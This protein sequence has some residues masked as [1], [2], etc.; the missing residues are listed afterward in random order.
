MKI[1]GT[2]EQR[3]DQK[4]RRNNVKIKGNEG[5]ME[6]SRTMGMGDQKEH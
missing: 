4:E 1:K 6:G 5:T 3:E 2:K